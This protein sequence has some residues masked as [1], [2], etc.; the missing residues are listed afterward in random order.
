MSKSKTCEKVLL[1]SVD[2]EAYN[3][4]TVLRC[5]ET[6]KITLSSIVNKGFSKGRYRSV[7]FYK[8]EK[9]INNLG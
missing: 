6:N 1:V 5:S 9:N 8:S 3:N 7:T 4:C 2:I